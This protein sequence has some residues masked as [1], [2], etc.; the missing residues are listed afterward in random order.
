MKTP[1][2]VSLFDSGSS[3]RKA[4]R[5]IRKVESLTIFFSNRANSFHVQHQHHQQCN[6]SSLPQTPEVG[7]SR[8][9]SFRELDDST[10]RGD[11]ADDNDAD[12]MELAAASHVRRSEEENCVPD[13]ERQGPY[14]ST[15]EGFNG[16][17]VNL[18]QVGMPRN[19]VSGEMGL[20]FNFLSLPLPQRS[21][22]GASRRCTSGEIGRS[23]T[24]SVTYPDVVN[25]AVS[26]EAKE[27]SVD[28]RSDHVSRRRPSAMIAWHNP[29]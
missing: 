22:T 29:T 16:I 10:I 23:T 2:P 5:K 8:H 13:T 19:C 27:R 11:D 17:L 9:S 24:E 14:S 20:G 15:Y 18:R 21:Q 6:E 12:E 25:V 3:T 4:E 1:L 28:E 7:S 26:S